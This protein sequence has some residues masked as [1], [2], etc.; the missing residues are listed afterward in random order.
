VGEGGS[1]LQRLDRTVIPRVRG[2]L[3]RGGAALGRPL[4]ALVAWERSHARPRLVRGVADRP[5][6]VALLAALVVFVGSAVHLDRYQDDEMA[7]AVEEQPVTRSGDDAPTEVGPRVGVDLE[8]YVDARRSALRDVDDDGEIRAIVSFEAYTAAGELDL[9]GPVELE[10]L[11]LRLP[12]EGE[13]PR[14]VEVAAGGPDDQVDRLV[15]DAVEDLQEEEQELRTLLDSDVDDPAFEEEYARR[16]D[17]IDELLD[18]LEEDPVVVF[19]VVV[20]GP[21]AA[22]VDLDEQPG[23]RLVDPVGSVPETSSTRLFGL[24]PEDLD[25]ASHGRSL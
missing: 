2:A 11:V 19:A 12:I 3:R 20:V 13:P 1:W 22:L 23:V 15:A 10:R 25:R 8:L 9:P 16:A 6:G 5:A 4:V 17:E 7:P 14:D 24:L 21:V 18:T